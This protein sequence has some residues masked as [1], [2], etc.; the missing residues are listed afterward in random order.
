MHKQSVE[1]FVTGMFLPF[2]ALFW[3]LLVYA[4]V[5]LVGCGGGDPEDEHI[6]LDKPDCT[7]GACK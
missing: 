5:C 2:Q 4:L 3:V 6:T 1:A 7:T